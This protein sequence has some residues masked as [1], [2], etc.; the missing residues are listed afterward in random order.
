MALHPWVLLDGYHL[1]VRRGRIVHGGVVGRVVGS[2]LDRNRVVRMVRLDVGNLNIVT[3]KARLGVLSTISLSLVGGMAIRYKLPLELRVGHNLLWIGSNLLMEHWVW[4]QLR[5]HMN[6]SCLWNLCNPDWLIR[7]LSELHC[8]SS[9][10]F[11][12]TSTRASFCW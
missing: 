6:R 4:Y 1:V 3:N 7:G 8:H 12:R 2:V 11:R 5:T 9:I 10:R